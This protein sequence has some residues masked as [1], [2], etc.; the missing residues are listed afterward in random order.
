MKQTE[1]NPTSLKN[2]DSTESLSENAMLR[3]SCRK[4]NLDLRCE[5]HKYTQVEQI[6]KKIKN[7]SGE[8]LTLSLTLPKS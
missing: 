5:V 2:Y 4:N 3:I 8:N 7:I 1:S 6:R